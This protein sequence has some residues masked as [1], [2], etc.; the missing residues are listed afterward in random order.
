MRE[1]ARAIPRTGFARELLEGRTAGGWWGDA[2]SFYRPKY[3]STHWRML[4]FADLGLS[5]SYDPLARSCEVWMRHFALK[6]GG[7]GG[8]SKGTG[9][10][11]VVGNMARALIR[12]GYADDPR[13]SKSLDW[14]VETADPNGGWSCFGRGRNLDS[15]EGLGA[16][17]AYPRARW[18][19]RAERTV[20]GAA[21]FFLERELHRQGADYAP[22]YRFHAPVHYYYDVLVGLDLLTALGYGDD[23]RLKFA[24]D[25]LL[26]KRRRDGRWNLDAVHP[27]VEGSIVRWYERH[28][29]QRPT[30][31]Q[32]E[33]PG[34]PSKLVTLT[35]L[36]VL[37]RLPS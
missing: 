5:R 22:W 23:R 24:V 31:L 6:G 21:E 20:E 17:A 16:F 7:V 28:P 11:C 35:A 27:D 25:L 3:V 15:W 14:L 12:F 18:S 2:G 13:V 36:N 37:R 26:S 4:A 1:A 30:P 19:A 8:N 29:D 10:H 9:H 33:T 34:R 32:L